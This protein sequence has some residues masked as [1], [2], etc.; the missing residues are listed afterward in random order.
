M[1]TLLLVYSEQGIVSVIQ[2][3]PSLCA[4]NI[5]KYDNY[6]FN[7][8]I[9]FFKKRLIRMPTSRWWEEKVQLPI[10]LNTIQ[11]TC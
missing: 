6:I 11:Q 3:L 4:L 1:T 5:D 10:Q 7:Q 8:V 2:S 9:D